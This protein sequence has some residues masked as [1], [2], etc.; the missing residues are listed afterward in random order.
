[1]RGAQGRRAKPPRLPRSSEP[2]QL[3]PPRQGY[4]WRFPM[5]PVLHGPFPGPL[6][7]WEEASDHGLGWALS[8][9]WAQGRFPQPDGH[10]GLTQVTG[11]SS[12]AHHLDAN[13]PLTLSLTVS[14]KGLPHPLPGLNSL[15]KVTHCTRS[16]HQAPGLQ[17]STWQWLLLGF[18]WGIPRVGTGQQKPLTAIGCGEREGGDSSLQKTELTGGIPDLGHPFRETLTW[19]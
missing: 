15:V 6:S 17:A 13:Q 4:S 1:M 16:K 19:K 11:T 7:K 3:R 2:Q 10:L 8:R 12:G 14:K 5:D 9:M 18:T